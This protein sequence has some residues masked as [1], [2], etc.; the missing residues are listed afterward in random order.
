MRLLLALLMFTVSCQ[1]AQ[2]QEHTSILNE[3]G[4]TTRIV[5]LDFQ[6]KPIAGADVELME[7]ATCGAP[8]CPTAVTWTQKSGPDGSV[9]IPRNLIHGATLVGA[10]AHEARELT[11]ARWE[12]DRG[13]WTLPLMGRVTTVCSKYDSSW[14]ILVSDDWRSARVGSSELGLMHCAEGK[15][16]FRTCQGPQIPDAGFTATFTRSGENISARLT[17]ETVHGPSEFAQLECFRLTT[18]QLV[19]HELKTWTLEYSLTGGIAGLHRDLRLAQTGEINV[20]ANSG[21]FAS[22]ISARAPAEL[23][24]KIADF[25]KNAQEERPASREPMP[26]AINTSLALI[27]G[28]SKYELEIPENIGQALNEAMESVLKTA[29][30]G[31]WWESR[32]DLCRAAAQLTGDQVDSPIERL[33]FQDNGRFSV[34]A[35][36]YGAPKGKTPHISVPDYSGKYSIQA[37]YGGIH[38]SFENG[39]YTP[40]DF[41]GDGFFRI[42]EDK[43]VLKNVWLGTYTAKQKPDICEMT[44]ERASAPAHPQETAR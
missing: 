3:K 19:P 5:L 32:W 39:I 21:N 41:S 4:K 6:G 29:L 18:G 34:T 24:A 40:R 12:K 8:K 38:L 27:S 33:V 35:R 15:D 44:F 9:N 14:I 17:G 30:V 43:L 7:T 28:G 42:D 37:D 16:T 2:E 20:S 11:A 26:D 25:L 13:A 1:S 22:H 10:H 31:V 36:V 23:V